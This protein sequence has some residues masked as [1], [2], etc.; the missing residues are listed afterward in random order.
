MIEQELDMP[1]PSDDKAD[2]A[3]Q[4]APK[5]PR[6]KTKI[7]HLESSPAPDEP[8][9]PPR[10]Y[11]KANRDVQEL[12]RHVSRALHRIARSVE[13]GLRDWRESTERSSRRRKDGAL[14]DA[15]ENSSRA[16][17]KQ[18]RV[19]SKVPR[20]AARAVRSLKISKA[21]RRAFSR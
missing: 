14:R 5:A 2:A 18:L 13:V 17:G 7:I 1:D 6:F 21:L 9:V 16:V 3:E 4:A 19:V 12:G 10:R 15:M 11:S 20:D 8:S